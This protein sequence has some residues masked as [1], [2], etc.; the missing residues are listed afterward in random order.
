MTKLS[1]PLRWTVVVAIALAVSIAM[2]LMGDTLPF[3]EDT[4]GAMLRGLVVGAVTVALIRF[5][6][7]GKW[8]TP[9]GS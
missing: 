1:K 8:D 6:R 2:V 7:L 5:M 4:M 3:G 9:D